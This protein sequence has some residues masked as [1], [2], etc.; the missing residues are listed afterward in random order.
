[1]IRLHIN[2]MFHIYL[3]LTTHVFGTVSNYRFSFLLRLSQCQEHAPALR[4]LLLGDIGAV[5]SCPRL[6]GGIRCHSRA[7]AKGGS[8]DVAAG[9]VHDV[10]QHLN[11]PQKFSGSVAVIMKNNKFRVHSGPHP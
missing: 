7:A 11:C 4:Q 8:L 5:T 10:S 6:I 3:S 9:C 1:M 2:K